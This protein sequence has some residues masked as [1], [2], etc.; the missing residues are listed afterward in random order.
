MKKTA[1]SLLVISAG[2]TMTGC[3]SFQT[4]TQPK[5]VKHPIVQTQWQKQQHAI[6]RAHLHSPLPVYQQKQH[7]SRSSDTLNMTRQELRIVGD[8]IF[9]NEC[10]GNKSNLIHWNDGENF[11]SMGI[12]HFTWYPAGRKQTHGNMFPKL[13]TFME[14]RGVQLP[15]WLK[16]AKHKG[17]PW[18]SKAEMQRAKHLPQLQQLQD[19]L[20]RTRDIQAEFVLQRAEKAIPRLMKATPS[21]HK[22]QVSQNLR[23]LMSTPSGRYALVDYINFKG[24]GLRV[25]PRSWGALQVLMHMR[26]ARNQ[27]HAVNEFANSAMFVL[28][29][30]A[31]NNPH[32]ARWIPGW[33]NR[34]NTYRSPWV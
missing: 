17:A 28:H 31:R 1:T 29:R 12:A 15:Y 3:S 16:E 19:L 5:K 14:Q 6:Q 23:T 7:Q 34:V 11:A 22:H 25:S 21:Q 8:K 32:D 30:R 13:L 27:H 33:R 10:G 20:Y 4:Q 18:R 9:N 26:P 2:L 24:E